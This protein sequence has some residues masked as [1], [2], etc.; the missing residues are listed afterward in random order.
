M[1]SADGTVLSKRLQFVRVAPSGEASFA[2]WAP[3][4][5]LEP[6]AAADRPLLD[7][8]L[9][10][11]WIGADQEQRALS[12][13]A[14][15]LVPQHLEEV[16]G[17]RVAHVDKT[18]AAVNERLTKEI[19]HWTDR[20][21][22]LREDQEGGKDVRLNLENVRRT[23][24]DLE[25]RLERRKRELQAMRHVASATPIALGGALVVPAGRLARL[26]AAHGGAP[27]PPPPVADAAVRARTERLAMEA[28]RR[29]EEAAGCRVVDVSADK[30]GWDLSSYPPEVGGKLPEA[31]HI[32]VKGRLKGG[33][34]ITVTRNEILYALNQA[35]RFILALV[36][37]DDQTDAVDGPYYL[38]QPFDS[39]PSWGVSS[40]SLEIKALLERAE[41][42]R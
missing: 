15:T 18:L 32:E 31:R 22:K 7:A 39:E 11:P 36:L 34:T 13:A 16:A 40:W 4:L 6:L 35:D 2:G 8:L 17:R 1:K 20:W 5:D 26:R 21:M 29:V 3:H 25:G 37:V 19:A 38:R 10:E 12:L 9:A 42:V 41:K 27:S 14:A 24:L 30:C 28:V 33:D 23:V